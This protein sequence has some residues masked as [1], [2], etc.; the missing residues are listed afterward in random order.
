MSDGEVLNAIKERAE[1]IFRELK[2]GNEKRMNDIVDALVN[3]TDREF[4]DRSFE[5]YVR[6]FV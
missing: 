4:D 2:D 5:R 1:A 3:G 6:K